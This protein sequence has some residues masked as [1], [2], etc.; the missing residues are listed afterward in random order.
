METKILSSSSVSVSV[1]IPL[2]SHWFIK[3]EGKKKEN[4]GLTSLT[5]QQQQPKKTSTTSL[6]KKI[7]KVETKILLKKMKFS[8]I[9]I[10]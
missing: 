10:N 6:L 3:K 5:Q 2:F 9:S 8:S 7:F 4:A 1:F